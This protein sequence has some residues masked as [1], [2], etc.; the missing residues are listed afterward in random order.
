MQIKQHHS[1]SE[2]TKDQWQTL[3]HGAGPFLSYDFLLALE[4]SGSVG[5]E[6]DSALETGWSTLFISIWEGQTL[7]GVVPGY[8]KLDSYGE[9]VFDHAWANAYA[10]YGLHYY[11]KWVAAIPFTPVTAAKLLTCYGISLSK[12]TAA[13]RE[14]E[15]ENTFSSMHVLFCQPEEQEAL[16]HINYLRRFS[17]QFQ[18]HNK[19]Y[20]DFDHYLSMFTSRKRKDIRKERAR[21]QAQVELHRVTGKDITSDLQHHFYQC[22]RQTYLK[23]SGHEGY[24]TETFFN[25]IFSE[26]SDKILLVY[27]KQQ[28]RLV[29]S[30]L[31]LFDQSG[32]YGRYWGALEHVDGLHFEACYYQGIEFAIE[33]GL[34]LFN[35]GTQ[36]EH[37][38]LRGFEPLVCYSAHRLKDPRFHSA[39]S[40]FLLRE[41]PAIARYYEQAELALPFN[42]SFMEARTA[43]DRLHPLLI[44]EQKETENL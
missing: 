23:R 36:G 30:S 42:A 9:Y 28:G 15:R 41:K 6:T 1:I 29:A 11:P 13:L 10:Q 19:H 44:T 26:M 16:C 5:S 2:F 38:L 18:W 27:A 43:L 12:L 21:T 25:T 24:L 39:V 22:Y 7:L 31:F 33:R 3:C 32:L 17:V 37:K 20:S 4:T 35:P 8:L 40:D 34:P 14:F